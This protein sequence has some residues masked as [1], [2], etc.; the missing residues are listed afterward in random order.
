MHYHH[1][2]SLQI[3]IEYPQPLLHT[4]SRSCWIL[5]IHVILLPLCV[6]SID[7]L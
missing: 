1:Y 7:I 4:F 5:S 6:L 2:P 3:V